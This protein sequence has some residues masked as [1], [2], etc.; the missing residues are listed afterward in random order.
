METGARNETSTQQKS[1]RG[2]P[3][4]RRSLSRFL[5]SWAGV[6]TAVSSVATVLIALLYTVP[7]GV[8]DRVVVT[9]A[10]AAEREIEHVRNA[11]VQLAEIDAAAA[12][13]Y[14]TIQDSAALTAFYA[15]TA[16]RKSALISK[17]LALFE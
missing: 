12:Q 6:A 14:S 3:A 10:Q 15:A 17:H 11:I 5:R 4:R 9:P 2:A 1:R 13:T 16:T 7:L 8:W